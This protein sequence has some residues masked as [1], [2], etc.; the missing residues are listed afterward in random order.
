VLLLC[1]CSATQFKQEF[2]GYFASDVKAS[3]NKHVLNFDMSASD[4]I[5]KIKD[6]L[7]NMQAIIRENRRMQYIEADN[8]QNVF[9]ST[10]DTTQVGI[11]VISTPADK[12]EVQIASGN[13]GLA[14][15]VSDEISK[16]LNPRPKEDAVK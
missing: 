5:T 13:L 1:G 7:K 10:I 2:I 16:N 9:D 6:L 3:E 15:F 11:L 8:F 12:C 14:A 4:C